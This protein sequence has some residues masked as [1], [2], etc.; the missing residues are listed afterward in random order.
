MLELFAH[1]G[2]YDDGF[3]YI[4]ACVL[5]TSYKVT[6]RFGLGFILINTI[7]LIVLVMI[8]LM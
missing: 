6:L 4:S 8:S 7:I 2:V 1:S 5:M 3:V